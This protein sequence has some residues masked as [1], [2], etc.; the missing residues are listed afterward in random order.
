[1]TFGK[2]NSALAETLKLSIGVA[3]AAVFG[4]FIGGLL[5]T[6]FAMLTH[7]H[8][9][10]EAGALIGVCVTIVLF[11]SALDKRGELP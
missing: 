8:T 9:P 11:G 4:L 6:P 10:I 1:M 5:G 2:L 3:I 7:A